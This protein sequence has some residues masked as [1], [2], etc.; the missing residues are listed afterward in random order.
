MRIGELA[1][2]TG[3]PARRLRYYEEQGL[4]S[5]DR[6]AN[7]YR[8]YGPQAVHRVTQIRGLI[9]A[10][11][12]TAIIK[13]ILPLLD[14]PGAIHVTG[15]ATGLIDALEHHREQLSARIQCITRNRDAITRYLN[16]IRDGADGSDGRRQ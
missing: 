7:G 15:P 14:S 6:S 10:G 4:L 8:D 11:I 12:P 5:S 2:R 16:A 13:D 3:V 1:R 9:D